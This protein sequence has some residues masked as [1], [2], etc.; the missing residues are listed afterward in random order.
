MFE[1]LSDETTIIVTGAHRSGTTIATEMIAADTGKPC[2]REEAFDYRDIITAEA[3]I[4][5]GG[6]IQGPYLLPWVGLW[7]GAW[8]I[9]LDRPP[10]EVAASVERLRAQGIS[11]PLFDWDQAARLVTTLNHPRLEVLDYHALAAHPLWRDDR[12]GWGHR[13]TW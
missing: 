11:L 8:V 10:A 1:H 7:P 9:V 5:Q 4:E 13:Q 6:V 3:L 2:V 12:D